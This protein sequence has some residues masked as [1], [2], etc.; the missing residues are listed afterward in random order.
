M[1]SPHTNRRHVEVDVLTRTEGPWSCNVK[2]DP[3][4]FAGQSL[5][6]GLA[7][8]TPNVPANNEDETDETFGNPECK[9]SIQDFLLSESLQVDP[10]SGERND[11]QHNVDVEEGLVPR[12]SDGRWREEQ[13]SQKSTCS[14]PRL[15]YKPISRRGR[16]LT[17]VPVKISSLPAIDFPT[18]AHPAE[19]H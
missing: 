1:A 16:P 5:N 4:C 11:G 14:L 18:T 3:E 2:S 13:N 19:R 15:A 17:I 12:M 8:S 7:R 10:Y 6:I 9:D